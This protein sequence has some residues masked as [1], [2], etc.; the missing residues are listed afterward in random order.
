MA[1]FGTEYENSKPELQEQAHPDRSV[2]DGFTII[3]EC[4]CDS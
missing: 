2:I 3:G 4:K 1:D